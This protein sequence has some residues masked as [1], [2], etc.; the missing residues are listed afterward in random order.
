MFIEIIILSIIIGLVRGGKLSRFKR[1]NFKKMWVLILA[2]IIQYFLVTI[3]FIEELH[4]LDGVF[5][6]TKQLSIISY[7]LLF[8][9]IIIN[10]RYRSLWVVLA[11][12][13]MNIL[14]MIFNGWKR[15]ILVEGLELLGFEDLGFLLEQGKL[16]LY[17]PIVEKTK[18]A[19]L[20][21][22]IVLP[23]PYPYPHIF[24]LGD[25]IIYLG[26]FVLIQEIMISEDRDF[27]NMVQFDFINR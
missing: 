17:T 13:V 19:I 23:K 18:L 20:G 9:G 26:L 1:V 10:L 4:Y 27:G 11:G 14:A 21:D 12:S 7:I 5:R 2:L 24:S 25:F 22:I 8:I 15:P 3:N 16:P 6:F